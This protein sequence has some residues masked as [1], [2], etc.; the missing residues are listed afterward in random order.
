MT[1]AVKF[2]RPEER[3]IAREKTLPEEGSRAVQSSCFREAAA[4]TAGKGSQRTV[5]PPSRN[6][7]EGSKSIRKTC[8]R[9]SLD[10]KRATKNDIKSFSTLRPDTTE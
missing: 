10:R 9:A 4:A 5:L 1:Q 3:L 8:Q 7:R 2:E 6:M